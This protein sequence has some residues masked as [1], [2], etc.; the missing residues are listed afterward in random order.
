MKFAL[1]DLDISMAQG[2]LEVIVKFLHFVTT[3]NHRFYPKCAYYYE[4]F[5]SI[6]QM[7]ITGD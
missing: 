7:Q 5:I 6:L 2:Y 3:A 4:L 1:D